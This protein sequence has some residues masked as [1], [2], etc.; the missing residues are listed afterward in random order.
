MG[1]FRRQ[2][3]RLAIQLLSW[4]YQ[5]MNLPLPSMPELERQANKLV[6]DAHRIAG[7][8]GRNVLTIIKEMIANMKKGQ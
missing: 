3:E 7:E 1:F 4:Q 2:E 8:R 6:D 5:K